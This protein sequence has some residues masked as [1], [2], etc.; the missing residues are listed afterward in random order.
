M[1]RIRVIPCLLI[2]NGG[3]VKSIKF[4]DHKYVGD[5]I[6]AVKIFNE[7]GADEIV[8]LDRTAN[9]KGPDITKIKDIASEAFM[10][11][12]YGGGITTLD[13]IKQLI[14]GGVEKVVLNTNAFKK[15]G[16][17]REGAR[18]AGS[19]SIVVSIDVKKNFFGKYKVFIENGTKNTGQDPIE[20]AKAV[21]V[22]GAGEI[23]LT[24]IDMDGTFG[25][26]DCELIHQIS[27]SVNVPVVASGGASTIQDFVKA[28]E[29]GASALAAGSMFVFQGPHRAVLISYPSESELKEK[30]FLH[31][32]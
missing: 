10:P 14:T 17:V 7:K 32:N 27:S 13:Q 9:L 4:K 22:A 24:S 15:K 20:Y 6:N 11:L 3:L 5:P 21:V 18:Y 19:Q 16:L 25:G 2:Q 23:L 29:N 8:I 26:F 28:V 31:F 1:K 12:S 30:L